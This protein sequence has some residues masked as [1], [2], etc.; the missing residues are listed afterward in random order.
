MNINTENQA[1]KIKLQI[2]FEMK[3][4]TR[5]PPPQE[6]SEEIIN[7]RNKELKV[8]ILM[9]FKELKRRMEEHSKKSNKSYVKKNQTNLKNTISEINN[10]YYFLGINSWSDDSEKWISKI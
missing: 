4:K 7:L 9:I 6:L 1:G 3:T 8:M 5:L 2:I 10:I